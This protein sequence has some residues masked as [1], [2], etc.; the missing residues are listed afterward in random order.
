VREPAAH[1]PPC[2][3]SLPER[4]TAISARTFKEAAV[5]AVAVAALS[6]CPG[7]G[8]DSTAVPGT[9]CCSNKELLSYTQCRHLWLCAGRTAQA[10]LSGPGNRAT[11][12]CAAGKAQGWQLPAALPVAIVS[13]AL[14]II[15]ALPV[16]IES[17]ALILL[18]GHFHRIRGARLSHDLDW[19]TKTSAAWPP[20]AHLHSL[21]VVH[22]V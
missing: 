1:P 19:S 5:Q 14:I 2:T 4:H 11:V 15:A 8:F 18:V 7:G 3:R 10:L 6:R 20:N 16:A 17:W 21:H 22:V 9:S 13:W 12:V